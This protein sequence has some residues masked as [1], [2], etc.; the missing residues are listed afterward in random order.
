MNPNLNNGDENPYD[1][2]FR[3]DQNAPVVTQG[4]GNKNKQIIIFVIFAMI[5]L[6]VVGVVLSVISSS[7]KP[8]A[9]EAINAEAYQA[10]IVR[11]IDFS[12]KNITSSDLQQKAITLNLVLL[13][14]KKQL[15]EAITAKGITTSPLQLE[16]FKDTKRDEKLTQSLQTD[17]HDK[18]FEDMIDD[19]FKKYYQSLSAAE[20]A[21][22]TNKEKV[23]LTTLKEHAE[24]I[25]NTDQATESPSQPGNFQS[26]DTIQN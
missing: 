3:P 14:D 1:F 16:Q 23:V 19:L 18:V 15:G 12:E 26:S 20:Q 11:L 6:T 22:S 7:S 9:T 2:I 21:A 10:E 5:V 8:K 25:Y 13:N 24:V 4:M 17:S